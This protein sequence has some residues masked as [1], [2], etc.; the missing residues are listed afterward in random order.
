MHTYTYSDDGDTETV[1]SVTRFHCNSDLS[2]NVTIIRAHGGVMIDE[3]EVP[4]DH[5]L[6]FIATFVAQ[7]KIRLLEQ[8]GDAREILGIKK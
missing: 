6:M 1:G 5:L 8:A 7:E 4:G 2:G 3:V